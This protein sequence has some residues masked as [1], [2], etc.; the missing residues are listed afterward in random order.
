MGWGFLSEGD[1]E[2]DMGRANCV[3]VGANECGGGDAGR[4]RLGGTAVNL[5]GILRGLFPFSFREI[6]RAHV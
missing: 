2:G 4:R 1:S 5:D 6:G 3:R